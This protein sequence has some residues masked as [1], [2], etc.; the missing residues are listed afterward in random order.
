MRLK[1]PKRIKMMKMMSVTNNRCKTAQ[2][3]RDETIHTLDV[4]NH[5]Y[6]DTMITIEIPHNT[7]SCRIGNALIYEDGHG[8]I[9]IDAE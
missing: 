8:A 6:P 7:V 1:M 3:A 2:D 4:L 9:V 5:L